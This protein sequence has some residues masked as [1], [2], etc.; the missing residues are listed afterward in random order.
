MSALTHTHSLSLSHTHVHSY[1]N[2]YAHGD[3]APVS[4]GDDM[5]RT[6]RY[7]VSLI[8]ISLSLARLSLSLSLSPAPPP[9]L[10]K[11]LTVT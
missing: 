6:P 3:A 5:D 11:L 10:P 4:S 8:V 2:G 7:G 9:S 1:L